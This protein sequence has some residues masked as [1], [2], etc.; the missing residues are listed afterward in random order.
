[1]SPLF[2]FAKQSLFSQFYKISPFTGF[3]YAVFPFTGNPLQI[4][5]N[6]NKY[7]NKKKIFPT[8]RG[9]SPFSQFYKNFSFFCLK[10]PLVF[11]ITQCKANK[12]KGAKSYNDPIKFFKCCSRG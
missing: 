11:V 7:S 2:F 1:M 8:E 10:I 4:N 6:I 9:Q 12:T 3:P 5:T